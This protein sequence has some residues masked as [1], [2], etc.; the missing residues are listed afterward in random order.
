MMRPPIHA[1]IVLAVV[2][3]I[4]AASTRAPEPVRP[5]GALDD[6][7]YKR[8]GASW[9]PRLRLASGASAFREETEHALQADMVDGVVRLGLDDGLGVI[10][11]AGPGLGHHG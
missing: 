3:A 5:S 4:A 7:Y 2:L 11:D 6:V 9:K 1:L 8:R 10:G